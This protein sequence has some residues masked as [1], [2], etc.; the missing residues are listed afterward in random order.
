[1]TAN[2]GNGLDNVPRCWAARSSYG[3][4][5][6]PWPSRHATGV[7]SEGTAGVAAGTANEMPADLLSTR[8]ALRDGR[9]ERARATRARSL[10]GSRWRT[11]RQP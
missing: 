7:T 2:P 3:S 10:S 1:M 8:R 4:S 9:L 11:V 6:P 5:A